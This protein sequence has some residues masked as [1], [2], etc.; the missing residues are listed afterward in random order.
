MTF[1]GRIGIM[2]STKVAMR[3]GEVPPGRSVQ[4]TQLADEAQFVQRHDYPTVLV[5][6]DDDGLD[7]T[8][9]DCLKRNGFHVLE[10]GDWDHLFD[11]A[12]VHS[13]R[14]HLLLLDAKNTYAKVP[15]LKA[16]RSWLRVLFVQKPVDADVVLVQVRQLLGS[17]P[18]SISFTER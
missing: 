12:R 5:A 10:A 17:P 13:R 8:L 3:E 9:I 15:I 16:H 2:A 6:R 4:T 14:I 18:S 11:V 7:D 1:A